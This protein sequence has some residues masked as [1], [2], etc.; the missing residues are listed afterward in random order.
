MAAIVVEEEDQTWAIAASAESKELPRLA[1]S[2]NAS[3][4]TTTFLASQRHEK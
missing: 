4:H 2:L 3:N 1:T